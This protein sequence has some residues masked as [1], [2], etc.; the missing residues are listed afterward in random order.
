ML[1]KGVE[2]GEKDIYIYIRGCTVHIYTPGG[3]KGFRQGWM[4][5]GGGGEVRSIVP[6][7][8][9]TSSIRVPPIIRRVSAS[10]TPA[11]PTSILHMHTGEEMGSL[12]TA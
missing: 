1:C 9:Q 8:T 2:E 12:Y 10:R 11:S 3:N 6:D 4:V 7:G 5:R